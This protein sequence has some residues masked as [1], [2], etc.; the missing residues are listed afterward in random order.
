MTGSSFAILRTEK[1]KSW[2]AIGGAQHHNDR[3]RPT[4]NADS[5][6]T[7][8]NVYLIGQRGD[9]LAKLTR[10]R[11]GAQTIRKNAVLAVEFLMTASPEYFRPR[12]PERGGFWDAARLEAWQKSAF[13]WLNQKYGD[14]VI[15]AVLH[16]DEQTPHIQAVM[17]PLDETGKLNCR[18]LFGAQRN[19]LSK[20]QDEYHGAVKH[21]GLDRGVK[22][23]KA[24]HKRVAEYYTDVGTAYT[25]LPPILPAPAPLPALGPA[26]GWMASQRDK[27]Q[28][29]AAL[30]AW[31]EAKAKHDQ[32]QA[33]HERS[34]AART[35]AAVEQATRYQAQASTAQALET[36]VE[37]WKTENS[38]LR[39]EIADMKAEISRLRATADELRGLPL[40]AVLERVYGAVEAG[41]S[42]PT[43]STRKFEFAGEAGN[44]ATTGDLWTDNRT[45]KG[46]KGAINLV[47]HLEGWGQD[48]YQQALRLL[49]EHFDPG[50]VATA[51]GHHQQPTNRAGVERMA[52]TQPVPLPDP[53]PSTWERAR[54][55]LIDV[56]KLPEALVDDSH[57]QGLIYS[58][59]RAN[60]VFAREGGGCF[61]RGSYDPRGGKLAFKQ[62]LG[63]DTGPFIL[64]GTDGRVF[65]TEAPI[66]ALSL[67]AMNPESTVLATGGN[68]PMSRLIPHLNRATDRVFLAQDDDEAGNQQAER[69]RAAWTP[70]G[71]ADLLRWCPDV[72]VKGASDWNDAL[73][74]RPGL[75]CYGDDVLLTPIGTGMTYSP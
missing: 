16:L 19:D 51:Y 29:K 27:E 48:G 57:A 41:D 36:L 23:S 13:D 59:E 43:Y 22:G 6:R 54:R 28:H 53:V 65:V 67:K 62:T 8:A 66:D 1:L 58:D 52:R 15:S 12:E 61:K 45:G 60:V 49:A 37:G 46:G 72:E 39:T 63:R 30:K 42:R 50:A 75:A 17:V 31:E 69:I 68:C 20:L 3:T 24:E 71:E 11:I 4:P 44:I 74:A 73:K 26:P 10:E 14:R 47:M 25:P 55:Y 64:Q 7:D 34:K 33:A 35:A 40:P 56:R 32:D 5:A 70:P 9:D 2:G 18:G 38:T 21:L